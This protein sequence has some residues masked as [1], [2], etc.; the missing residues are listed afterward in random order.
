MKKGIGKPIGGGTLTKVDEG[1]GLPTDKPS[2]IYSSDPGIVDK[3]TAYTHQNKVL[4]ITG[5][6]GSVQKGITL[7]VGVAGGKPTVL[8]NLASSKEEGVDWNA[9]ILKI[10]L[11]VK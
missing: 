9:A 10:A 2:I 1:A 3:I 8:L 5:D 11:T 7:G 4:S 6:P